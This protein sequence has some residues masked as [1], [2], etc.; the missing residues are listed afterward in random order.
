M[1]SQIKASDQKKGRTS[2]AV[3]LSRHPV[4]SGPNLLSKDDLPTPHHAKCLSRW[5]LCCA[6]DGLLRLLI[7]VKDVKSWAQPVGQSEHLAIG[8]S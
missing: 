6:A 1:Q 5:G 2:Q 4:W 8:L 7:L 3:V